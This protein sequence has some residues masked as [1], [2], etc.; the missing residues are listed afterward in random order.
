[1]AIYRFRPTRYRRPAQL[2]N[3][4][5]SLNLNAAVGGNATFSAPIQVVDSLGKTHDLTVNFT[6]TAAG[7]WSYEV[8]IPGADVTSGTPG[9][10]TIL[11]TGTLAFDGNGNLTSPT[12]PGQVAIAVT[13]LSDGASDMNINWNL[14][15]PTMSPNAY[16]VCAPLGGFRHHPGWRAAAEVTQVSLA[17]GGSL[18]AHFSNG[19]QEVIGQLAMAA[20]SNPGSLISVGNSNYEI[21]ANTA[22]P[23]VGSPGTGIAE[24]LKVGHWNL[25]LLIL[26][27]S[28]LT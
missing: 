25:P 4:S 13:G 18:I 9:T 23:V 7:N 6:E 2:P 17:N 21:G 5:I 10:P 11:T 22:T 28:S 27:P 16:A 14:L 26:P 8:D 15:A 3:F 19:N 1:M 24:A 12:A 20:I